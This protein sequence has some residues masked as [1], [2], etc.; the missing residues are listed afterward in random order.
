L[1]ECRWEN[2]NGIEIDGQEAAGQW[3]LAKLAA[4]HVQFLMFDYKTQGTGVLSLGRSDKGDKSE[5]FV[6]QGVYRSGDQW[7]LPVP[8]VSFGGV[9]HR[10]NVRLV[11]GSYMTRWGGEGYAMAN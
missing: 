4:A 7:V 8:T 11:L 2:G 6:T 1:R 9:D 3:P 5:G 10:V